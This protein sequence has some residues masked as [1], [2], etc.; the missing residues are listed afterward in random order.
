M[1]IEGK[2]KKWE[3]WGGNFGC[4]F[5][6]YLECLEC[7]RGLRKGADHISVGLVADVRLVNPTNDFEI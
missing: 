4:L 7:G 1:S 3:F 2:K 5:L 6:V